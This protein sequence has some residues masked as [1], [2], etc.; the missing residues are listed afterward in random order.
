[1]APRSAEEKA[2]RQLLA[3]QKKEER[4]ARNK[5]KAEEKARTDAVEAERQAALAELRLQ[6]AGPCVIFD[7]PEVVL[8]QILNFLPARE[9]ACVS[10]TC[11]AWNYAMADSRILYLMERLKHTKLCSD[12]NEARAI[13]QASYGGGDTKRIVTKKQRKSDKR[14][15]CDEFMGYARFLEEGICGYSKLST[16]KDEEESIMMPSSINGRYASASPE[17]SL[18]RIGGD[19]A[20]SGPGGSGVASWGVGRRGQ[21]GNAER[22]DVSHP[23]RLVGSLGY[24]IRV[25]QVS[26]GGGLVR[27]AHSLFLTDTG[28]VM[29][30]GNGSYGQLGQGYSGAKQLPDFM[31]PTYISAFNDMKMICVSAGEIHSAAVN[32]DGDLFTFGDGFLGMLGH[33]D[34]RPLVTPKQVEQGGLE[35]ECVLAVA[36]GCRH[37]L[38]VTEE[39]EVWSMGFGRYGVLGRSYTPYE[40]DVDENLAGGDL[41]DDGGFDQGPAAIAAAAPAPPVGENPVLREFSER[42]ISEQLDVLM[43]MTLLDDTSDQCIP[44]VI[45]SMQGIKIV[46]A[47]AG[48]RHSILLDNQGGI[49]TCGSGVTGALGHGDNISQMYPMKVMEFG[50]FI[51]VVATD[52]HVATGLTN[53][54]SLPDDENIKIM[55]ISAGV[56]M[57][58]AVSTEGKVYSWGKSDGGRLGLGMTAGIVNIP[59]QVQLTNPKTDAPIKAIDAE[60]GYMHC[61]IVGLDGTLHQCGG[62]GINGAGDGQQGD[63]NEE[64]RGQPVHL[65]DLNIWHRLPELKKEAVKA[66]KWKKYGTYTVSGRNKNI[67]S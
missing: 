4:D 42:G 28:R 47:S 33:G 67:G 32:S 56:D 63:I 14:G 11:K 6:N 62:V 9:L 3:A 60:C 26:A 29:S 49:Y 65:K 38:A 27:V 54:V 46:G 40:H 24:G 41:E 55:Q 19:G 61:L 53:P 21:L 12:Q 31:K 15:D 30:C 37:T 17:H 20:T 10:L 52:G 57:S 16:G 59:R 5:V 13:L 22:D 45:D 1:M 50:K 64:E 2:E 51:E 43:N 36:C 8:Q 23:E 39:G 48:H 25:V 34:K 7:I 35:D 44:K 58:M 18:T 66:E